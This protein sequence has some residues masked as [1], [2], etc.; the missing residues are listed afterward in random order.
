MEP[1]DDH[2][3]AFRAYQ[4]IRLPVATRCQTVA[5]PWGALWHTEDPTALTLRNRVFRTRAA[6]D[7]T[8]LDW[9]YAERD[10]TLLSPS[11]RKPVATAS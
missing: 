11:T 9:L 1:V 5:R 10:S 8:D 4:G 6:D 7:Y 2:R 3:S